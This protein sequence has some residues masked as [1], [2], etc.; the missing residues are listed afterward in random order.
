MER[1]MHAPIPMRIDDFMPDYRLRETRHLAVAAGSDRTWIVARA[2][3]LQEALPVRAL[4]A[5]RTLPARLV[6]WIRRSPPLELAGRIED[7]VK[8]GTGF[9]VLAEDPGREVGRASCRERV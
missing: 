3:D 2:L 1:L 9:I 6:A 5:I 4:F 7:I 8:P